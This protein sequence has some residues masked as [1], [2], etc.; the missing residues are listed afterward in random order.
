MQICC[1]CTV[2][3]AQSSAAKRFFGKSG[4][5]NERPAITASAFSLLG[6]HPKF[7]SSLLRMQYWVPTFSIHFPVRP[8]SSG[9]PSF[10]I[11]D[12]KD[13][14]FIGMPSTYYLI[15]SLAS[16]CIRT[17]RLQPSLRLLYNHTS[18]LGIQQ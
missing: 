3:Q 2:I 14:R 16:F 8:V 4:S 18:V 1:P 15:Q 5:I 7:P 13:R 17:S 6:Q 12:S 9:I 11:L 10:S